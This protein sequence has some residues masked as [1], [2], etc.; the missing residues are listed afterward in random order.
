MYTLADLPRQGA[1]RHG[2]RTAVV[3]EDTRL[4]YAELDRRVNQAAHALAGLGLRP[5][6]R[7]AILS[8]NSARYLEMY[9][10]AAKLGVSVTPLNTRLSD[11]ELDYTVKDSEAVVVVAG[12][13][14]E[15]RASAL[16]SSV[17]ALR[18]GLSLDN[19]FDGFTGYEEVLAQAPG[20]EPDQERYQVSEDDLAVLMYTGGTTGLP[21]GVMLSHRNVMTAA[22]AAALSGE[23]TKD[24]STCFVL[25]IFH[26]S[27]WPVLALLLA[28]GKVVINRKPDLNEILRLVQDE[29]CTHMNAV[30]TI[31]GWLM[32][33]APVGSYD[34]SSLRSLTYA[35]SPM[36]VEVLK[37]AITVFGPIFAQGYGATETAG[38]PI[39]FFDAADHHL[40][41]EDSHLL[42]SAGKA[43][44]CSEIKVV[45]KDGERVAPG[46][47]GEVCVR[48]KHVMTGYWKNP[49]LTARALKSGWYHTGD[50]GY[51]D[52][53]GYLF[54]TDRKSDLI[55][56]GGENVYPTEVENVLY[57]HPAVLE[58]SVVGT[59][60]ERWVEIVHAVIVLRG[61]ASASA[62]EI[63]EHCHH[64]LAGY[65]CPKKVT[66]LP[67]LPKTAIGKI[68]RKSIKEMIR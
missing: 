4:T 44:I 19:D 42:A 27:W 37:R 2:S 68:S 41:G 54:L 8:D 20:D 14:Y 35:G 50:L 53:C 36:P 55:I 66:F 48:G 13:G 60:D 15:K 30:P 47:I 24:D 38:G 7:L 34:L 9:L 21:K 33:M 6:E 12:D 26:V 5:G 46:Q 39:T 63:I 17:P 56:T 65:K 64:D 40:D 43:G 51:L 57:T 10:A 3:Y 32:D 61:G 31:Y 25:P 29:K 58:C 23:F 45:D 11:P 67:S 59:P 22:I 49:E 16:L 1:T 28:G 62:E 52:E 18:R